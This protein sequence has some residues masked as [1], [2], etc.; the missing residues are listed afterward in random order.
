MLEQY[1]FI[2]VISIKP[3]DKDVAASPTDK[4]SWPE[5]L[6]RREKGKSRVRDWHRREYG[7]VAGA[8]GTPHSELQGR[9][10]VRQDKHFETHSGQFI[11]SRKND[12]SIRWPSGGGV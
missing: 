6:S 2:R 8:T 12:A 7:M 3:S 10:L 9:L 4:V 11:G 1:R 5:L